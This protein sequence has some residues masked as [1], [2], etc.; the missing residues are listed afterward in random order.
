VGPDTRT[1]NV[2]GTIVTFVAVAVAWVIFRADG[3]QE[4]W[5]LVIGLVGLNG[6]FSPI[7][8]ARLAKYGLFVPLLLIGLVVL[9]LPNSQQY[10]A[11]QPPAPGA[12]LR[13]WKPTAWTAAL[14]GLVF[15]VCIMRISGSASEFIYFQF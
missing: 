2:A 13:I 10:F 7:G 5:R 15:A 1:G 6:F 8:A 14:F 12:V 9:S 4:A 3:L 11:L